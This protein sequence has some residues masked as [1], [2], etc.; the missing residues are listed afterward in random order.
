MGI[1]RPGGLAELRVVPQPGALYQWGYEGVDIL[2]AND[3]VYFADLA[4][5]YDVRLV[6]ACGATFAD[7]LLDVL[8]VTVAPRAA[9]QSLPEPSFD[10]FLAQTRSEIFFTNQSER[11]TSVSWDFGDGNTSSVENPVHRYRDTGTYYVTMVAYTPHGCN[12]TVVLGP[13]IVTDVVMDEVPNAF[14]PNGRGPLENDRLYLN[15][16]GVRNYQFRVYNRWGRLVFDNGGDTS[17]FWDGTENNDGST[18]CSEGVYI[19]V[20][21]ATLEVDGHQYQKKGNVTIIR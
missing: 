9:A 7:S 16:T 6:N 20:M 4:G 18:I 12:D 8:D 2:G 10:S 17:K 15:F 5:R 21:D 3:T 1:C 19:W 11:F 14:T 13:Y